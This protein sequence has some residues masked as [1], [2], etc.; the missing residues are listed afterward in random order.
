[1]DNTAYI[2]NTPLPLSQ[3]FTALKSMGLDYIQAFGGSDWTN[4]NT[5]DPGIT[6]LD[7]VVYALT[8][9]G[10]TNDFPIEDILTGRDGNLQ[11]AGRFYLPSEIMCTSPVTLLDYRQYIVDGVEDVENTVIIPTIVNGLK[12]YNVWVQLS[13]AI[14]A[15]TD[16]TNI[17][18]AVFLL[19][20]KSRNLG[21][22]FNVCG[23]LTKKTYQVAGEIIFAPGADAATV[24]ANA[25]EVVNEYLFPQVFEN[26]LTIASGEQQAAENNGP[27]LNHNWV[28]VAQPGDIK[29]SFG[30][31][32]LAGILSNLPGITYAYIN[33]FKLLPSAP[34]S[35][36]L[37]QFDA[38]GSYLAVD[39]AGSV[40][41]GLLT[42][43]GTMQSADSALK[44][45]PGPLPFAGVIAE[46][47]TPSGK[48]RDIDN[49]YSI[50]NTF[51]DIYRVG[52]NAPGE[53]ATPLQTA[54]SRQLKGYL[55]LFD[56]LL[57]NQFA[58]LANVGSLLSFSNATSASPADRQQFYALQDSY[59]KANPLYPV[60]YRSFSPTYFCQ[61]LYQVPHIK[62]LLKDNNSFAFSSTL[63]TGK[64]LEQKSWDDY[65]QD[66]YN[67]YMQGL[68]D[69]LEDDNTAAHRRNNI[70]DHLLA[71]HGESP[72]LVDAILGGAPYTG[73]TLKDKVI[74]KSL[75]LQNLGLLSY[76]RHKS[77]NYQ[78]ASVINIQ[79]PPVPK[80]LG[81]TRDTDFIVNMEAIE[82]REKLTDSDFINYAAIELKI[83][84]L[85]GIAATYQDFI[86]T[87]DPAPHSDLEIQ[88]ALWMIQQRKGMFLIETCLLLQVLGPGFTFDCDIFIIL[89]A[90][91]PPFNT[92]AFSNRLGL[93]LQ[94]SLP[95]QCNY[96]IKFLDVPAL[97]AMIIA[98]TNWYNLLAAPPPKDAD[99]LINMK[100]V[101]KKVAVL[102]TGN[103][104]V[105]A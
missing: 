61:S 77:Y 81:R 40:N 82:Q 98:F 68:M 45:L 21:E 78:G 43:S 48:W 4:F 2:L 24:L 71:R 65:R 80:N 66:P 19:L 8:E 57:A 73:N 58:Q 26:A 93:L 11:T 55:T 83:S 84:L 63:V 92:Q 90:F 42:L 62:P 91:V 36:A 12:V 34:A 51:P 59:Q 47:V 18:R 79:L 103:A 28:A 101:A 41:A 6:I 86:N 56:Q 9:L 70:L 50:Q 37:M 75:Y 54:R 35:T 5:A 74:I 105:H 67:A 69:I 102:L 52:A 100:D 31:A 64:Q 15:T 27:R 20:N 94:C 53:E 3:D 87:I 33:S 49:Y 99:V 46:T 44:N 1:M 104:P 72:L 25:N 60:P 23:A 89:P 76:Y 30:V 85:L 7:Q 32:A 17:C 13:E 16:K 29:S 96:S 22:L 97:Q 88:L 10:Y 14:T 38:A 39:L 95:L